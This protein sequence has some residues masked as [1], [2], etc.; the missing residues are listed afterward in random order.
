[1]T[2]VNRWTK[3]MLSAGATLLCL[4]GATAQDNVIFIKASRGM[5]LNTVFDELISI[6]KIKS[7]NKIQ[8]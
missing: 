6:D 2:K 4:L 5:K 3:R 1:M 8:G 7:K